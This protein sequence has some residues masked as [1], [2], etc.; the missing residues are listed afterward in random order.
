MR[1]KSKRNGPS[2]SALRAYA[3]G[4]RFV[5]PRSEQTFDIAATAHA[6]ARHLR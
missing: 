1:A 6:I 2:T 3:Q 5:K 4:E